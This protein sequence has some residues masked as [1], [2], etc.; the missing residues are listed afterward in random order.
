M[1]LTFSSG[2]V[3]FIFFFFL[4]RCINT[5]SDLQKQGRDNMFRSVKAKILENL[6]NDDNFIN[7]WNGQE[8]AMSGFGE[9][10]KTV[11]FFKQLS[12]S[13]KYSKQRAIKGY[14]DRDVWSMCDFLEKLFPAMLTE[15]KDN[16]YGSPNSLVEF[17]ENGNEVSNC[18]D[19]WDEILNEMIFLW[20]ETNEATCSKKNQYEKEYQQAR[21]E[22]ERKYGAF[23]EKLRSEKDIEHEK[24]TGCR[25]IYGLAKAPEYQE[26]WDKYC[27]EQ[28][29]IEIY[30]HECKDK[31]FDLMKEFFYDLWD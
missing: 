22:F 25:I 10:I 29:N 18:H 15:L 24:N 4:N 9:K 13:L 27:Q 31:A 28:R 2:N 19:K 7:V 14:C 20:R 11:G 30:R 5:Y 8:F 26:I 1:N 6:Y 23:G 17:D 3:G 16:R 21:E 12:K